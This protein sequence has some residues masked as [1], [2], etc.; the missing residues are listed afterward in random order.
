M[1]KFRLQR[2]LD[3]REQ[4]E[5]EMAAELARA[6]GAV[7]AARAELANLDAVRAIGRERLHA[8]HAADGTVGE[9]RN[10]VFVLEQLDAQVTNAQASVDAAEDAAA[11][12]RRAGRRVPRPPRARPAARPAPGGLPRRR[13]VGGPAGDGR[14]RADA[15]HAERR[16]PD[17]ARGLRRRP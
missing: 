8:A 15:L 17:A 5:R 10:L 13:R 7:D 12:A 11:R 2:L 1:F 16:R 14:D 3:L 4:K 9:L 6:E